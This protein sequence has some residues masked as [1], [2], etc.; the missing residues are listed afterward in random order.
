M[1]LCRVCVGRRGR[2]EV[3]GELRICRLRSVCVLFNVYSELSLL[4]ELDYVGHGNIISCSRLRVYLCK[5][6]VCLVDV[7]K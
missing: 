6:M 7:I 5:H 1:E 2:A 4:F 3:D